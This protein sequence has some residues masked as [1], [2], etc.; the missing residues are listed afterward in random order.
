VTRPRTDRPHYGEHLGDVAY[1]RPWVEAVLD[2][3]GLAG[4]PIEAPFVGTFPT[5]LVGDVVVKLFGDAFDGAASAA[6]ERAV[7]ELLADHPEIPAPRLVATGAL[8]DDGHPW[9]YLVTERFPGR[10]IRD[11]DDA[12]VASIAPELGA[13]VARV[14]ALA[15]PPEV[16]ARALVPELRA[17]APDRLRRFGLPD[18]LVEQVPAYL[19]DAEPPTTLVH[20]DI[21]ADHVFVDGDRL[22]GVIDWGDAI[23]ADRSY[24]VP[25]VHFD[26][27]RGAHL[28][29]F[30]DGAG[31]TLD[32]RRA[33]QGV[34]EFQFDAIAAVRRQVDLSTVRT[35]DEL[36]A[37]LFGP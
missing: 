12:V 30:L 7:H 4:R 27:L 35:L 13:L 10:A 37:R 14:H 17:A 32:P 1:W 5:F 21:T 36:A 15:A 29:A 6:T 16:A 33:L 25:A 20:A 3:H 2:R 18:H 34:L 31:W 8:Y 24:E 19:A 9:P 22:V 11:G 23:V 28:D 26:A